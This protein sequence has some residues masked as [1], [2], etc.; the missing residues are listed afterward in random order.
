[1]A[2]VWL[3]AL[4]PAL[5]PAVAWR[6]SRGLLQG[7]ELG[8]TVGAVGAEGSRIHHLFRS[9]HYPLSRFGALSMIRQLQSYPP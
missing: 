6:I 4:A 3:P 8:P 9:V 1:M 5:V 2:R 7:E